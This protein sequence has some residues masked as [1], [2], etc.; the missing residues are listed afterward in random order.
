MKPLTPFGPLRDR[1]GERSP[2]AR[3]SLP[4]TDWSFQDLR[5]W[6]GHSSPNDGD[7][8]SPARRF[9]RLN[10]SALYESA[11]EYYKE[12]I[13]FGMMVA[14]SGWIVIYMVVTAITILAKQHPYG[15]AA[16]IRPD[17]PG[18]IPARSRGA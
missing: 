11:Q 12:L 17:I 10:R 4:R 6:G 2:A 13:V 5:D 1:S 15:A 14:A 3:A 18:S 8:N 9:Q 16:K 7:E